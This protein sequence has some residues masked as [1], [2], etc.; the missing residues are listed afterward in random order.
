MKKDPLIDLI[1]SLT[2]SE[3]R[4]FKIFSKRHKIGVE[5]N[6]LLL[7]D[8]ID[9]NKKV[10]YEDLIQ[11]P[12][13]KNI[14]AEKK[15]LYSQILK[16]LNCYYFE[17]SYKMKINN[18]IIS[19]ELLAHKGLE[20]Q[21]LKLL[22]KAYLLAEK[23]ELYSQMTSIRQLRFEIFS[24]LNDYEKA[25]D[26]SLKINESIEAHTKL[27]TIQLKTTELYNLKQKKG[28]LKTEDELRELK[29]IIKVKDDQN[30]ESIKSEMFLLSINA[31]VL[32]VDKDYSK[33]TIEL[34]KLIQLYEQNNYL[35]EHSSKGYVSALYNLANTYRNLK[36]Y[37]N[38]IDTLTKMEDVYHSKLISSS[39]QLSAYTFYLIHN[40]RLFI[41]ILNNDY[42][43]AYLY[44]S[45]IV[46]QHL[47][48][49]T[50]MNKSVVYEFI[51]ITIRLEMKEGNYKKALRLSNEIINDNKF[52][53]RED[54][55]T[56]ARLLNL[57]IHFELK[58]DFTLS[59]LSSSALSY[60]KRKKRL[61]STEKEVVKFFRKYELRRVNSLIK[62]VENLRV[63]KE[64]ELENNMFV[65]FDFY[66]WA[67]KKVNRLR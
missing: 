32:D 43:Q 46:K 20:N 2:M 64:S 39:K 8:Y 19:S 50:N 45:K 44:Y 36:K 48:N 1:N 21:A 11:Q 33:K 65:L 23:I 12:F 62:I 4:F 29:R 40:L 55:M 26:N 25:I 35:I 14:S 52:K 15:Y 61:F 18:L 57:V 27:N 41:F 63:L 67:D 42:K 37:D 58:N 34:K 10:D 30:I 31:S 54:I 17:F 60:F 24:K 28:K 51:L 38:A 6:Y 16:S 5:N 13:V 7:F 53:N 66:T 56:Y 22:D 49:K 9:K 47:Q 59:Y 3:K